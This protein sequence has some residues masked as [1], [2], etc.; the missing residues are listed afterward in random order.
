[1]NLVFEVVKEA[2]KEFNDW[3]TKEFCTPQRRKPAPRKRE[4]VYRSGPGPRLTPRPPRIT[5]KMPRLR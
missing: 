2:A 5:P 4:P 3:H 1:M